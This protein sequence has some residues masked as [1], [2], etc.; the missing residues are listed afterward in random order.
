[1]L[2][3][4]AKPLATTYSC[5]NY[6]GSFRH[7][8]WGSRQAKPYN[9][10]SPYKR[11]DVL[12]TYAEFAGT[13]PNNASACDGKNPSGFYVEQDFP[14]THSRV[15]SV[16]NV[17]RAKLADSVRDSA[18]LAVSL[19]EANE[20]LAMIF[21]RSRQMYQ[22]AKAVKRFRFKDAAEVLGVTKDPRFLH[23]SREKRFK[24]TAKSFASNFLEYSWGWM[25]LIS[26]I[27]NAVTALSNPIRP[28]PVKARA[29][30]RSTSYATQS[31]CGGAVR[32]GK[33]DYKI[34]AIIGCEVEVSN[35]NLALAAQLGLLDIPGAAIE[36]IPFSFVV[37]YFVNLDDYFR[38][39]TE[40]SGVRIINPYCTTVVRT[41]GRDEL[42]GR[43]C[44]PPYPITSHKLVLSEGL[45][46]ERTLGLP[47]VVLRLRPPWRLS[48][49]RAATSVALLTT[50]LDPK[51]KP[52]VI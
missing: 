43:L 12:T 34:T 22:F 28:K 27:T 30:I 19:A 44:N 3:I 33:I 46:V 51:R 38:Q 47:D 25:P 37:N 42:Y 21:K 40:F 45:Y 50:F 7:R 11:I 31:Y 35:A 18:T 20:S 5:G 16:M 6:K 14:R 24:R 4:V 39:F 41:W 26:D 10:P 52:R 32:T 23:A 9:L 15:V 29:T 2:P 8:V 17:A 13:L 48:K 1:M 36:I 49:Q